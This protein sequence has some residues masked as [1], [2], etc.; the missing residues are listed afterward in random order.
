MP[1]LYYGQ[2]HRL[3]ELYGNAAKGHRANG[4]TTFGGIFGLL[5]LSL[6]SPLIAKV[7]LRFGAQELFA[8]VLM[9]LTLVC[10]FG[11]A[12]IVKALIS[13]VLGLIIMTAG[14]DPMMGIPRFTFGVVNLQAGIS[15]LPAMIGLFAIP[16]I[17]LGI[18]GDPI[19]A[20]LLGAL[21]IQGLIP[22]P[23]LFLQSAQ[24][25]YSV[26]WRKKV[27]ADDDECR[28]DSPR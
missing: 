5:C 11:Q 4:F 3:P 21:I 17:I 14:L 28:I 12:S 7:A 19:T 9:R 13:V 26:F 1:K 15:F 10:S 16:Q 27:R 22:G 18:P 20:I 8:L 24:F 6:A 2:V 23:M 25:V